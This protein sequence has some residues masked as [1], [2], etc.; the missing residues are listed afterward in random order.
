MSDSNKSWTVQ[1]FSLANPIGPEIENLPLLLRRLADELER[2]K[3]NAIY[4]LTLDQE[5]TGDG[6]WYS[7]TTYFK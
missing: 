4:D 3:P 5:P 7:I 1:A 6:I 2:V